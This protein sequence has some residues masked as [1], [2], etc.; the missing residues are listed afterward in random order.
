MARESIL[1]TGATGNVGAVTLD[2]LLS[3]SS[4]N[5]KVVLRKEEYIPLFK[6]KYPSEVA[7]NRLTFTV[8][9]DMTVSGAFDDTAS[10]ATAIIHIA[11]P[12]AADNWV[13]EMILPTWNLDK[14]ILE[15]AK[16]SNSVQRVVICGTL[17]QALDFS[18]LSKPDMAVNEESWNPITFDEAKN[19]PFR[20]AYPYS[21][22][23]AER[24]T[25]E[26]MKQNESSIN[27]DVVVLLPPSITGRSPQVTFKP[28]TDGPGGIPRIYN[29][30]M[31]SKTAA[32]VDS[33]FP[34]FMDT[35]DVAGTH[36]LSLDREKVPGNRRYLLTHPETVNLRA[37]AAKLRREHPELAGRLPDLP[38]ED[39][40]WAKEK[41]VKIDTSKA[42]AVFGT[43]WTDAYESIKAIVFD[44]LRWE[45]Q[46]RGV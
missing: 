46:N 1:L 18:H 15:A 7:N 3:T 41:L 19:G 30:L 35:D 33:S 6:K 4:H 17:L 11:T 25:W 23:N 14:N 29:A 36:I 24:K 37:V 39:S 27:F 8:I 38:E 22:T 31:M 21:K 10:S 20:S 34:F 28:S 44:V 9:P 42:D 45:E 32:D 43:Q 2:H 12:L 16:K 13:E 40:V 5:V 26:W